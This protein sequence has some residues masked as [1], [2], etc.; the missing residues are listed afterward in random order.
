MKMTKKNNKKIQKGGGT[1]MSCIELYNY[2]FPQVNNNGGYHPN[3]NKNIKTIIHN[4][5]Q[6]ENNAGTGIYE[7]DKTFKLG[8]NV[9]LVCE[10]YPLVNFEFDKIY[11]PMVDNKEEIHVID[12]VKVPAL[13]PAQDNP[14]LYRKDIFLY[15]GIFIGE[16]VEL[17]DNCTLI[18]MFTHYVSELD[19]KSSKYDE[20]FT[21]AR[22]QNSL[23]YKD[24][25]KLRDYNPGEN[26]LTDTD[27]DIT[28]EQKKL[29][30]RYKPIK[31]IP[32]NE[33]LFEEEKKNN[34]HHGITF[35]GENTKINDNTL[36]YHSSFISKDCIIGSR[37]E[38]CPHTIFLENTEIGNNIIFSNEYVKPDPSN[39]LSFTDNYNKNLI[40]FKDYENNKFKFRISNPVNVYNP[41]FYNNNRLNQKDT[42]DLWSDY[43]NNKHV[44]LMSNSKIINKKNVEIFISAPF[45]LD[46]NINLIINVNTQNKKIY[47]G[48]GIIFKNNNINKIINIE[49][50]DSIE[51]DDFDEKNKQFI[52][53]NNQKEIDEYYVNNTIINNSNSSNSS[54][55]SSNSNEDLT[56][57]DVKEIKK[58]KQ[59]KLFRNYDN[60]LNYDED[61]YDT[62]GMTSKEGQE[63][64]KKL[65]E[66]YKKDRIQ[67]GGATKKTLGPKPSSSSSTKTTKSSTLDPK[68][69]KKDINKMKK[70][71]SSCQTQIQN[72]LNTKPAVSTTSSGTTITPTTDITKLPVSDIMSLSPTTISSLT[73]TQQDQVK[74]VYLSQLGTSPT[75]TSTSTSTPPLLSSSSSSSPSQGSISRNQLFNLFKNTSGSSSSSSSSN[76]LNN[77]TKGIN[78][79]DIKQQLEES[80]DTIKSLIEKIGKPKTSTNSFYQRKLEKVDES[81]GR[82]IIL[83]EDVQEY[84]L[85]KDKFKDLVGDFS[86]II[87]DMKQDL[88]DKQLLDSTKKLHE[89]LL[90][91][92]DMSKIYKEKLELKESTLIKKINKVVSRGGEAREFNEEF[93]DIMGSFKLE[94]I[95]NLFINIIVKEY[96]T[97]INKT[98]ITSVCRFLDFF[99]KYANV[100]NQNF[101]RKIY[102][103]RQNILKCHANINKPKGSQGQS[104]K[105]DQR[106]QR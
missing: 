13:A 101:A 1:D 50:S 33:N 12:E 11:Y 60:V 100:E 26:L 39:I 20:R 64:I 21:D 19:N 18:P 65:N 32:N 102:N 105:R 80:K 49:I 53:F 34:L 67:K 44:I 24:Y 4:I 36:I 59:C 71:I 77:K 106:R 29:L 79:T 73:P 70:E 96:G 75:S 47:L 30:I 74:N 2:E 43:I 72:Y 40:T 14:S 58:I 41:L 69:I 42:D 23:N 7:V 85:G 55:N 8:D 48:P 10:K 103:L 16:N 27:T 89:E 6:K 15:N 92:K 82:L 51:N 83:E 9:N 52:V 78:D 91:D 37:V 81:L 97:S 57:E 104:S 28:E 3:N 68:Q 87:S 86:Y 25:I 5:H 17:E 94:T 22:K 46:V 76:M 62:S 54:S 31:K 88:K 99:E 45:I 95:Q 90:Q 56:K 66:F 98:E 63:L 84:K 35:I 93:R 38:I 61:D